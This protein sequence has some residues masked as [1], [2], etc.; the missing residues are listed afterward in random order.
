[1]SDLSET[2]PFPTD[3][4]VPFD[5]EETPH[6]APDNALPVRP[7]LALATILAEAPAL[8]PDHHLLLRGL[9]PVQQRAVQ[10]GDGPLLL[11]AG[12]GSGKTRV[13]THRVAYLIAERNVLPRHILA[14]TFT[15]KAAQE[16]K[17]RINRLVGDNVGKHLWVGTFHAL[18]ARLLREFGEKIGID[19]DFVVYDD[20]DQMTL[21][22]EC[23]RQ[24]NID[25][26]KFAPRALLARIS[27]A[28]EKL[29]VPA[30][31][32]QHFLGF[33]DDIAGKVYPVYQQKLRDN[34]ALD[35]DDLL[36]EAVHLLE[37]RPEVLERLQNR[38]RYI[39]VDEYQDVNHVQY[40]LLKHL[41]A[42]TY[43]K[44]V[45]SRR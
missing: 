21:M 40:M 28:K 8:D 5:A 37:A 12:A 3:A 19:R 44:S 13:L 2:I 25:E 9:N 24:L 43:Q 29:V 39:M 6:R 34:N 16:M 15:N 26:K 27:T 30:D 14:V 31:W 4:D 7:P 36:T 33:F 18:C 22:K 35:F 10:H 32:H 20:A 1:M 42:I 17:E 11:F 41:A 23:L 38:Y 45:Y